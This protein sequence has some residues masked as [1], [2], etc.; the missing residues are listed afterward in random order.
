[1]ARPIRIDVENGWYH[2]TARGI[3]RRTIFTEEGDDEHFLSLLEEMSDRY[4]VGIH[5]YALM[6]NHYHL[7]IQTPRANASRATQLRVP[8]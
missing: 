2:V 8:R 6:G 3:E 7:L 4:E 1:M 5:G